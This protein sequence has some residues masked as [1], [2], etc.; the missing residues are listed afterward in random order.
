MGP[1]EGLSLEVN[2]HFVGSS[3]LA[4]FRP[5]RLAVSGATQ[6]ARS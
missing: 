5:A 2:V 3:G 1:L 4:T 6:V